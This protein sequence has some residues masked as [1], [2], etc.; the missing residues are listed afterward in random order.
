MGDQADRDVGRRAAASRR[1]IVALPGVRPQDARVRRGLAFRGARGAAL[2][3]DLYLPR[4]QAEPGVEPAGC[5]EALPVVLL[6]TAY[7]DPG[8]RFREFGPLTSWARLLA[9]SGMAAV[10]FGAE[11]PSEDV[12]ALLAHIRANAAA[13]GLDPGRCGVL[14]SSANVTVALSAVMNDE[15]L[16]CAACLYGYTLDLDGSTIVADA[17]AR[18]GFMNACA[19]RSVD[20]LPARV[21]LL[22]V[23]AGRDPFEGVNDALD[24]V[25]A[26][27]LER[28]LPVTV[29][30]HAAAGHGFDLEDDTPPTR[31]V[32]QQVLAFLRSHL[33]VSC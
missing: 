26:R 30:N 23:R 8:G 24:R 27:G 31:A 3:M 25:I 33:I 13:L 5:G 15:S 10:V 20:D 1:V 32:M 16:A 21:P 11:S 2:S 17:A 9:A 28:N 7:P 6:P 4:D 18:Y 29:I 22:F 19:G 14:A 12:N